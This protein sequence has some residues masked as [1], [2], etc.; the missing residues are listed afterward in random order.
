MSEDL[1][2]RLRRK[3]G[4]PI[5][6]RLA[7]RQV[8]LDDAVMDHADAGHPVGVSVFARRP[9]MGRPAGVLDPYL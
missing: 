2:V 6:Q 5:H 1:G 7:Q 3:L 9:P 8:I 4:T